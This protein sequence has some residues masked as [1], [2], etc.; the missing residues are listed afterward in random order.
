MSSAHFNRAHP[1][2]EVVRFNKG[3]HKCHVPLGCD[4]CWERAIRSDERV[5]I[6]ENLP[7]LGISA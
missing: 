3:Q 2:W 7:M 4:K 6:E 5:R 1:L